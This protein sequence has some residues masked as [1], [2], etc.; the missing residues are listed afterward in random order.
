MH[1]VKFVPFAVGGAQAICTWAKIVSGA[2]DMAPGTPCTWA[3]HGV[4]WRGR[5]MGRGGEVKELGTW[6]GHWEGVRWSTPSENLDFCCNSG[7]HPLRF[8]LLVHFLRTKFQCNLREV[9]SS[10]FVLGGFV[11]CCKNIWKMGGVALWPS[12]VMRFFNSF[13]WCF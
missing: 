4:A 1:F 13:V 5:G 10:F 9:K 8:F 2:A 3:R 11:C 7:W 6:H 12:G